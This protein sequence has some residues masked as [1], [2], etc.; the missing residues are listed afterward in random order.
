MLRV[1]GLHKRYGETVA[2]TGA[3][4]SVGPGEIVGLLGPNGAGKTT[5]VSIVAGLRRPDA[6]SVRV[7][8]VDVAAHPE[9]AQ[10]LIG[11][12]PQ[13]TAVYLPLTARENL[14]VFGELAGI[15]GR[16]LSTRIDEVA[17]A[18]DLTPLLGR[19]AST[20]SGAR[21]AGSTPRWLSSTAP[22]RAPRR[23]D[24]RGRRPHAGPAPRGRP[25]ARRRR[26]GGRV[27]HP[28]PAR[29]R[30][31][32]GVGGDHRP[33]A[34]DRAG[35]V[36]EMVAAH[37]STALELRFA[38][39]APAVALDG[40]V[41]LD[42]RVVRDGDVLRIVTDDPAT[43][44]AA[45]LAALGPDAARLRSLDVVRPSLDRAFLALTGRRYRGD[46]EDDARVPAP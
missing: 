35:T 12:A 26:L 14:V 25:P 4:L 22:A 11:L 23:A 3:D 2:L 13:E 5:L 32:R 40:K 42:G 8:D 36:A 18:L 15:R 39:T 20:L 44:A 37:G 6:G 46:E 38:G 33:G 24:D 27:L 19:S 10:P 28:L 34:H 7:G 9:R 29:G 30:G 43:A 17:D 31:P 41:A 1:E 16:T 45:A 21:S